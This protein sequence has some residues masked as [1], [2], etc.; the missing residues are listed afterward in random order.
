MGVGLVGPVVPLVPAGYAVVVFL[1][2]WTFWLI[3]DTDR[4]TYSTTQVF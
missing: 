3:S 4:Q 2:Q 1:F